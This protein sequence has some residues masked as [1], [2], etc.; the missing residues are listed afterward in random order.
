MIDPATI[1]ADARLYLCPTQT[2]DTPV[3]RDGEVAR[4]AGGLIWFAAY[5]LVAVAGGARVAEASVAVRDLP[6]LIANLPEDQAR[7]LRLLAE[8]ISAP[9]TALQLGERT[10]RLDQPQVMG[11]L[12][13]TPDSFSDGGKHQGDPQAIAQAGFDMVAGGAAIVDVGGE[14]TRPGAKAVWEGDEIARV[15]GVVRA[16]SATGTPVSIDTRKAAVME[17]ALSAGATMVNDVAALAWDDRAASGGRG[18]PPAR[19]C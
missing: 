18:R 14:S 2:V 9:R 12:N 4:L 10:I 5:D 11:I 17:A 6:A 19:S 15:E 3:G 13:V 7:R 16:L 1:P 8:R